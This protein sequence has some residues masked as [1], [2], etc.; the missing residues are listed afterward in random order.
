MSILPVMSG[1]ALVQ[2]GTAAG[3][4]A[5][6]MATGFLKMLEAAV[7]KGTAAATAATSTAAEGTQSAT[8]G[9]SESLDAAALRE[10]LASLLSTFR[11]CVGGALGDHGVPFDQGL[12][13]SQS[14]DGTLSVAS[15]GPQSAAAS[16]VLNATPVLKDLFS[17]IVQTSRKL[18]G[19]MSPDGAA[20]SRPMEI[21]VS[22]DG[23]TTY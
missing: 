7:E 13:I 20:A 1:A 22:P 15:D 12:R 19:A 6:T 3:S 10:R 21:L 9:I 14:D 4:A 5:T 18:Q 17:A 11:D 23:A 8:S 2:F 16:E